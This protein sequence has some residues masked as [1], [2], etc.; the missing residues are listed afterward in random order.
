LSHIKVESPTVPV[1][2]SDDPLE[3]CVTSQDLQR[4]QRLAPGAPV[5]VTEAMCRDLVEAFYARV[6]AD[7]VLG[8]IFDS[9]IGGR[10]DAHLEKLTDFWSSVMLMTGRF[11]GAPMAVHAA[12]PRAG[13]EDFQRW[14]ALFRQTAKDVCPPEAAALFCAKAEMIAQSLQLGIAA[15]RGELPPDLSGP[16]RVG[17][18]PR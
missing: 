18:P 10:W 15:S 17:A 12:L 2:Y 16:S 9:A 5:G 3:R 8:P 7:P 6:R 4:R 14:L 1:G 13:P 11:K